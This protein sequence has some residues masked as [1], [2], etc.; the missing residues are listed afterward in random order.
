MPR[1]LF[2]WLLLA[3]LP[4]ALLSGQTPP[5]PKP[6]EQKKRDLKYEEEASTPSTPLRSASVVIPRSYALVVGISQYPNLPAS[7][8]LEFAEPDADAV[9]RVLISPEGGNFRAENV[10]RLTG[11]KATL[12]NLKHEVEVWLPS[13]AKEQD[14]VLIYFAGH[15]F[16]FDG[17]A[18][19]ASYDIHPRNV[20]GTA[21]P[22]D[23]LGRVIGSAIKAK[24]KVLLTDS[25]HSGA[26]TPSEDVLAINRKLIDLTKSLFSLTASR[27]REISFEG[28]QWGGGHGVFTYYL[29]KGLEGEADETQDGIVTADELG[30]YVHY[31]VRQATGGRQ[32]PTSERGSFDPQMLLSYLPNRSRPGAPPA[33]KFGTLIVE[34]NMDGV[35]VFVNGKSQGVVNKGSALRLPGM[36]PGALTIQGVRMGYEPDGP[37][38][39]MI[40]PGQETTV[41]LR[42]LIPVRRKKAALDLLDRGVGYYTTGNESN[43]RRAA[44]L[45][46]KAL[47]LEPNFSQ[48][49]L[50]LAR[51]HRALYDESKAETWFRKAIEID[52][53]YI[54]ARVSYGGMLLDTGNVDE[55]VRQLSAVLSRDAGHAQAHYLLAQ[56]YRMKGAY[57]ESIESARKALRVTPN[58]AEAHFWLAESLRMS[59][60]HEEAKS[61]YTE[62]LR[63]SDFDSK[64]AGKLNYYVLGFL[65]GH[66]KK[67]RAAQHDIWQD[68]RSMAYF[69]ICDCDRLLSRFDEAIASCQQALA[70]DRQDPHV[71]YA[72]GW[73][74]ARKA[75]VTGSL[76]PLLAARQHF[77][78]MLEINEEM[79]EAG[80]A[81][82]YISRIDAYLQSAR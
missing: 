59:G 30:E 50:Y 67:K 37:R 69:G 24:W 51:C 11:E 61:E 34:A 39:E 10:H 47:Q 25:C 32:N 52:P 9:Y 40:Y 20:P 22:M 53:D 56:A 73:T 36:T 80:S 27:D 12:A 31:N 26:I 4:V 33:P 75:E 79:E 65:I 41:T 35:E 43:Y 42:I 55:T 38:E 13:T 2:H 77:R 66:G 48:A 72:L 74:Y 5:K 21:Y 63:L 46:E 44:E 1:R 19:L 16:V 54:E 58:N 62:Y 68:L 57:N 3:A 28:K 14:R 23:T 29:V 49:A 15:G 18:Y 8:Q 64:L 6:A 60:K 78:T 45:F 71:H 76:E 81:R 7:G 82:R 70:Y 17:K